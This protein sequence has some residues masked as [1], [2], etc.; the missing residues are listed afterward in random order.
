[1][2]SDQTSTGKD[3]DVEYLSE[4]VRSRRG[5]PDVMTLK[6]HLQTAQNC[7][8]NRVRDKQRRVVEWEVRQ[9]STVTFQEI[10]GELVEDDDGKQSIES[11]ISGPRKE[12]A[13]VYSKNFPVQLSYTLTVFVI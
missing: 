10:V 3:I 13:Q 5:I 9:T 1:L 11:G 7:N 4:T 12:Y 6:N 2:L 8:Q